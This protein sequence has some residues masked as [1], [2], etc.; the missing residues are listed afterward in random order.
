[1]KLT[2]Q[3]SRMSV[4]LVRGFANSWIFICVIL[5]RVKISGT[6][7][8]YRDCLLQAVPVFTPLKSSDDP[9]DHFE[10]T[11]SVLVTILNPYL[12]WL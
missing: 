11:A 3:D 2:S 7:W 12:N 4:N 10:V 5:I 6:Q 8:I 1:V 9:G